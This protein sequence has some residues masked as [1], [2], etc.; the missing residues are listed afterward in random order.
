MKVRLL[1]KLADEVDGVDLRGHT[2]GETFD[3]PP[4]EATLLLAEQW[5]MPERRERACPT[6]RS[7]RVEDFHKNVPNGS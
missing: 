7:R 2:V 6:S 4:R 3:L 1:K 5:A